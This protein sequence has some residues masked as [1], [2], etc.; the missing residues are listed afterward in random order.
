[1][2]KI[3]KA[4]PRKINHRPSWNQKL[5]VWKQ[6][7]SIR[8]SPRQSKMKHST[9]I[10]VEKVSIHLLG[11]NRIVQLSQKRQYPGQR[12]QTSGEERVTSMMQSPASTLKRVAGLVRQCDHRRGKTHSNHRLVSLATSLKES[13]SEVWM[14]RLQRPTKKKRSQL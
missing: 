14:Y 4:N 13:R 11:M 10:N 12:S 5:R 8:N 9:R 2:M 6:I 7:P 1:M 3:K